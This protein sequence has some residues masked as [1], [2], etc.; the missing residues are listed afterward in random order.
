MC[1]GFTGGRAE[2]LQGL[3]S[4]RLAADRGGGM[5]A[6]P[7]V[8]VGEPRTED[9]WGLSGGMPGVA[10]AA[11]WPRAGPGCF[12]AFSFFVFC[13]QVRHTSHEKG[14]QTEDAPS[15]FVSFQI[16]INTFTSKVYEHFL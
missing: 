3:L 7:P 1:F 12:S 16:N 13:F 9:R 15:A 14:E 2:E 8:P 10:G 4:S 6:G 11:G 5:G